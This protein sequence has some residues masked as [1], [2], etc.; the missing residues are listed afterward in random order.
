MQVRNSSVHVAKWLDSNCYVKWLENNMKSMC[1]E[2][3]AVEEEKWSKAQS[4]IYLQWLLYFG[5][6]HGWF[7]CV[8]WR[9]E[10]TTANVTLGSYP[11]ISVCSVETTPPDHRVTNWSVARI[12]HIHNTHKTT[13]GMHRL[14]LWWQDENGLL[15]FPHLGA[16]FFGD[17]N[18]SQHVKMQGMVSKYSYGSVDEVLVMPK[19]TWDC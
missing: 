5:L 18:P 7:I 13:V 4:F 16:L 11:K 15:N 3:L 8:A 1:S 10:G 12:V 9:W 17:Q 6:G 14:E 19:N 2:K